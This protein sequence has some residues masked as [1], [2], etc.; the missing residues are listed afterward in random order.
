MAEIESSAELFCR[1]CG[2][3]L[4]G[5]KSRQC[6][7][8]G[9]ALEWSKLAESRIPWVYRRDLGRINAFALTVWQVVRRPGEV[10][11]EAGR[12]VS[13]S[14][15]QKFRWVVV[16]LTSI[17][18]WGWVLAYQI[19][20]GSNPPGVPSA[21]PVARLMVG[22]DWTFDLE[23]TFF[24]GITLRPVPW[25][26][27]LLC[28]IG[29]TGVASYLFHPRSLPV[30]RQDRAI[31]LSYYANA[32][33]ALA[34][35]PMGMMV[36]FVVLHHLDD[37]GKFE[38]NFVKLRLFGAFAWCS[39]GLI[40]LLLLYDNLRLLYGSTGQSLAR[41]AAGLVVLPLFWGG[42]AVLTLVILPMICGFLRLAFLSY[43]L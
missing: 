8:C 1:G 14:D 25:V 6:P 17:P 18:L 33:L 42:I 35:L 4:R 11:S 29:I 37:S 23:A 24:A 41:V 43:W 31:A 10:G 34:W 7:E 12:E 5:I 20:W 2:Y 26:A 22:M 28:V 15:A 19:L 39:L 3:N 32:S 40:P 38:I 16:I 13:Y 21:S 27:V 30:V 36:V 9:V